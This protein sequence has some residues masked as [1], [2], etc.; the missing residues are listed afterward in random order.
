MFYGWTIGVEIL[1]LIIGGFSRVSNNLANERKSGMWDANRLTPLKPSQLVLGYWMGS[2][3]REFYMALVLAGTGL[4]VVL[5]GKLPITIWLG[6]QVLIFST[7]L[8]FG[9]LAALVGFVFQ[10]P[11]N[12]VIFL[13]LFCFGQAISFAM[14][15]YAVTNFLLPVYGIIHLFFV[16]AG[17]N[18]DYFQLW[19]GAPQI[20]GLPI[21]PILLTLGLQFLI[22]IF[23]WRAAL[24]KTANPFQ[25]VLLRWEAIAIFGILL[26]AQHGLMW[27]LWHG[28]FSADRDLDH[29]LLP[30]F[31]QGGTILLGS[32]I[33]A[34]TCPQPETVRLKAMRLGLKN[35]GSIF[36]G[37]AVAV[38][39]LL[40]V[41][42]A[43]ISLSQFIR[44]LAHLWEVYLIAVGNLL[45]FFLVFPLLLDFCRLR[46][47]RRAIG[48]VAL[49][50]FVLCLLPYILA[51][52]FT[53][54]AIA[55]FSLLS[56][57]LFALA[58]T[59]DTNLNYLLGI[60]AGHLGIAVLLFINWRRQWKQ[61][62]ARTA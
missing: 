56:P 10:R 60:V 48:F 40:T 41:V 22:G 49:W 39:L 50:L 6:S 47:R 15:Q 25:P 54:G 53:N 23:L 26:V 57:G 31:V 12:A 55:E 44:D 35:V 61:L 38:G 11:Q 5:L 19:G 8:F 21:Y 28:R 13:A 59:H 29:G 37:S 3:L 34:C 42:A 18:D 51:V 9:L 2:P 58:S 62:L 43:I 33:L 14:P 32:I 16:D 27:N 36:P 46:F 1:V 30:S 4:V 24:R 17:L 45:A 7:A 52:I 20:F